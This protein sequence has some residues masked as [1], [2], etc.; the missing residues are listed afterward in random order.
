MQQSAYKG[1]PPRPWIRIEL[2]GPDGQTRLLQAVADTGNPLPL[3]V[4]LRLTQ[5][6]AAARRTRPPRAEPVLNSSRTPA[7]SVDGKPAPCSTVR[8][9]AT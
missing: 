3:I 7:N 8:Q 5:S 9:S 2:I 1:T 6:P 4:V